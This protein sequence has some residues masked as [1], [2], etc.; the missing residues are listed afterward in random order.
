VVSLGGSRRSD[1]APGPH[2]AHVWATR[3]GVLIA[4]SGLGD[5]RG[6]R[7]VFDCGSGTILLIYGR[8][9]EFE[10]YQRGSSAR[11]TAADVG[12]AQLL[13]DA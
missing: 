2:L 13:A 1:H 9:V 8:G 10:Q 11:V 7:D 4:N 12:S 3:E 5:A 6:T